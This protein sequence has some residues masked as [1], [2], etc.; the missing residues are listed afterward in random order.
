MVTTYRGQ[1]VYV[2]DSKASKFTVQLVR[3]DLGLNQ[4]VFHVLD[5]PVPTLT[6]RDENL[7]FI[8][9]VELRGGENSVVALCSSSVFHSG[10]ASAKSIMRIKHKFKEAKSSL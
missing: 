10:V 1:I 4:Y 9:K 2:V 5:I 6:S 3:N 7:C 8:A